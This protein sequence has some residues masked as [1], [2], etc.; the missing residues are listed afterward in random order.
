MLWGLER[1]RVFS[2][3]AVVEGFEV[4]ALFLDCAHWNPWDPLQLADLFVGLDEVLLVD[5]GEI[6]IRVL[7]LKAEPLQLLHVVPLLQLWL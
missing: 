6:R 7:L 2:T 3:S 4:Y 1:V 5:I